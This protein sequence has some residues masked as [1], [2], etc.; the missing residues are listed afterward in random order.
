[1]ET[2]AFFLYYKQQIKQKTEEVYG[3]ISRENLKA[4]M[5]K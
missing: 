4:K 5:I 3:L 1:M 2:L